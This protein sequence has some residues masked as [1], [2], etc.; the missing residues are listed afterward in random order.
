MTSKTPDLGTQ[1]TEAVHQL[2]SWRRPKPAVRDETIRRLHRIATDHAAYQA[3]KETASH[4][5]TIDE[6]RDAAD[7]DVRTIAR[8]KRQAVSLENM[9]NA[10]RDELTEA[11][12][13]VAELKTQEAW[14][15]Q[16]LA[17]ARE[18]AAQ[19]EG[20]HAATAGVTD[21]AAVLR[22][23]T[24]G[25]QPAAHGSESHAD[26]PNGEPK[27]SGKGRTA[28]RRTEPRTGGGGTPA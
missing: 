15:T 12:A 2:D 22:D 13:Q 10:L 7:K 27:G 1:I 6:L 8:L 23:P 24:R 11:R 14:L 28:A 4:R 18:Q 16:K 17:E 20:T 21:V 19:R 3:A 25:A 9:G 26:G 5:T